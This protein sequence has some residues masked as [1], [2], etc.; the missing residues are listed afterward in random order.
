M[1]EALGGIRGRQI[2]RV[3]SAAARFYGVHVEDLKG[4]RGI[5]KIAHARQVAM[6]LCYRKLKPY[7]YSLTMIGRE[8]G[9]RHYS[10]IIHACR[11]F[12]V[13]EGRNYPPTHIVRRGVK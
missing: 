9:G 1:G 11:K 2:L 3:Q 8:F 7:G 6:A 5:A 4:R 10:T 12:G 13:T